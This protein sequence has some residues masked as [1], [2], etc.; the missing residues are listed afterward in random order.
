[1]RERSR[2]ADEEK[3]VMLG[4]PDMSKQHRKIGHGIENVLDSVKVTESATGQAGINRFQRKRDEDSFSDENVL[5]DGCAAGTAVP[6]RK[7]SGLARGALNGSRA[8]SPTDT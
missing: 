1:M 7:R 2:P 5:K 4:E 3:T 8:T 6:R